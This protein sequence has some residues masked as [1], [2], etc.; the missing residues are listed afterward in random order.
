MASAGTERSRGATV[1][2]FRPKVPVVPERFSF[3]ELLLVAL[4]LTRYL[5]PTEAGDQGVTLWIAAGWWFVAAGRCWWLWRMGETIRWRASLLDVG[6]LA[7][8][9]GHLLSGTMVLLGTGDQRAALNVMWEWSSLGVCYAFIRSWFGS[10]PTEPSSRGISDLDPSLMQTL[11]RNGH[12]PAAALLSTALLVTVLALSG[13]GL[14]QY[15]VWYP[16]QAAGVDDLLTLR[17][18]LDQ[19]GRLSGE[20]RRRYEQL[21]SE[22]GTEVLVLSESGRELFLARVRESLE[23]IGR[24]ALGNTFAGLLAVGLILLLDQAIRQSPSVGWMERIL[25]WSGTGLVGMN[26]LLTKS[27][28]AWAGFF[29]GLLVLAI[30]RARGRPVSPHRLRIAGVTLLAVALLGAIAVMLGGLDREVFSEAPKSLGYRLEYWQ[31]TGTMLLEH[32]WLGVGPGNFRQHYLGYKLPGSSEEILDPHNLFLDVWANGGLLALAG[33][34]LLLGVLAGALYREMRR[35]F[36]LAT[37]STTEPNRPP[38]PD[39]SPSVPTQGLLLCGLL[40][41]SLVFSAEWLLSGQFDSVLI[42]VGAAWCLIA[43]LVSRIC[44]VWPAVPI[45]AV[46]GGVALVL[47][48]CGAGG[49]GMPAITQLLLVLLVA[50]GSSFPGRLLPSSPSSGRLLFAS[51]MVFS[52]LAGVC[53]LWS[54]VVPVVS[55]STLTETGRH[56][57]VV[58]GQFRQAENAFQEAARF[59]SLSPEPWQQLALLHWSR[60]DA[61][62]RR[63][64]RLYEAAFA[65]QQE[66]I[67]RD[68]HSSTRYRT[69]AEWSMTRFEHTGE[70][71]HARESVVAYREAVRRYPHH[72]ALRAGL[73]RALDA[74][75]EPATEEAGI[76]LWLDDLN[77]SRGHRDKLLKQSV[78]EALLRNIE[79]GTP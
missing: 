8:I 58:R 72:A 50:A 65:A 56:L 62:G 55:A 3:W 46:S 1:H 37:D 53:C 64:H 43:V 32:P 17:E 29:L 23:P 52:L 27:R 38:V 54:S 19:Q 77:A 60:W 44:R 68:P 31:S 35:S 10:P 28:T 48:L 22:F 14:W 71:D 2:Q 69:L 49:I 11:A 40:A 36:T 51:G 24:F 57:M 21:V 30:L 13:L 20:E 61:T 18:Q 76:A 25:L 45:A 9:G 47:H 33:L 73:A 42:S 39:V 67:S 66:A 59:D 63:D 6:V 5:L 15:F 70:P 75:G 12:P 4:F 7:L 26:L 41:F 34:L 16:R 79:S 78:R 74:L